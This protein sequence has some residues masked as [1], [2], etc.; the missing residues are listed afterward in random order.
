MR[1]LMLTSYPEVKNPLPR[2]IPWLTAA[3]RQAGCEVR[4]E[5][6]GRR[7]DAETLPEKIRNRLTDIRKIRAVLAEDHFDILYIHNK[8]DF[9]T[10]S[11]D[12]PLLLGSKGRY[13]RAVLHIHGSEVERVRRNMAFKAANGLLFHLLDGV[14]L[15]SHTERQEIS[16][17]FP[18]MPFFVAD[19]VYQPKSIPQLP[20]TPADW[21]LPQDKPIIFFAA[22]L[23]PEKGILDLL[24]AMPQVLSQTPCHLLLAGIGPLEAK[25]QQLI[26]QPPLAGNATWVG[27]LDFSHLEKAYSLSTIFALPTYYDEGFPAVIQDALGHGLPIVTCKTRGLIDHLEDGVHASL[28]PTQDPA[29]LARS[30]VELLQN[31]ELRQRMSAANLLKIKD[32]SPLTVGKNYVSIFE[33]ILNGTSRRNPDAHSAGQ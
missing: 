9:K 8:H 18:H 11:R 7:H 17:F 10:I 29:S 16:R 25:V 28:V 13:R 27:Y 1:V 31:S 15:S 19:N 26:S 2:I 23:I 20:A 21:N 6:W 22:R 5:E 14:I 4:E 3:L 33:K 12:V 24:A 32:F 30:L